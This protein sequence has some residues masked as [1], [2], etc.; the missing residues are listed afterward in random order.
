[1]AF[2]RDFLSRDFTMPAADPLSRL[3]TIG[4]PALERQA[5]SVAWPDA[6]LAQEVEVLHETLAAFR[7]RH[8]FGRAIAAPQLGIHKRFIAVNLDGNRHTL[9]N[10][11]IIWRSSKLFD[12]WDDCMSVP[13]IEVKE[14]RNTSIS[15]A[16][17][18]ATGALHAWR[19]LRADIS[20]LLQHEIDHLD[21]ILMLSRAIDDS[22]IRPKAPVANRV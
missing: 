9:V 10:P 5:S 16:F 20:E 8:G 18:N 14:R 22:S 12:V 15:V 3:L 2:R 19:R 17:A 21:G 4:A 11:Y 13:D 1:M 6:T 7:Q